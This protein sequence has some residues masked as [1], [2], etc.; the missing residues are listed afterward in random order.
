MQNGAAL[1]AAY[2]RL[3]PSLPE[4]ALV[5]GLLAGVGEHFA[6]WPLTVLFDRYHPARKALPKLVNP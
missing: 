5:R 4:S 2:A 6:T 1:C 3:K